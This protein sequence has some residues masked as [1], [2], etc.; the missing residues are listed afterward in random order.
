[1]K[2]VWTTIAFIAG[3]FLLLLLASALSLRG[4]RDAGNDHRDFYA[5]ERDSL[6]V[7]FVGS[8]LAYCGFVPA[9]LEEEYGISSYVCGSPNQSMLADYLWAEE[10]W[11]TQHYRVLVVEAMSFP[12]SHGDVANDLR[13]LN[14]MKRFSTYPKLALTYKRESYK[15]FFPVF[16]FH[17]AWETMHLKNAF[18][19]VREEA[20]FLR[21][22]VPVLSRA[23]S[24]EQILDETSADSAYLKFDYIDRIAD[25]CEE[26]GI[27]LMVVKT[28]Q[29]RADVNH[30][31]MGTHNRVAEYCAGRNIP[32]YDFNT[33]ALAQ[34]AGLDPASD[35]AE[36]GRHT[37]YDGAK[38]TTEYLGQILTD[39][40]E[41]DFRERSADAA[42]TGEFDAFLAKLRQE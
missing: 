33:A 35:V 9:V 14:T 19:P 32:F 29:A 31:D 37:N 39:M 13:S 18:A 24:A 26:K 5:L 28:L 8:S 36:D 34:A 10:A 16:E 22:Y 27:T 38:K 23:E 12:M 2:K 4:I 21:G 40:S 41:T 20:A 7:L 17:D 3:A 6:D 30:W 15:V 1:M 11:K 42:W 25:F